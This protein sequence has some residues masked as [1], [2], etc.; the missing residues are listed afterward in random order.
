M[1]EEDG[2]GSAMR[3]RKMIFFDL[4]SGV[5]ELRVLKLYIHRLSG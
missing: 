1:G 5:E 2:E 3:N 4:R